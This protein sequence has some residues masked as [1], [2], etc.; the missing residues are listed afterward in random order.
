[1]SVFINKSAL[2][3]CKLLSSKLIFDLLKVNSPDTGKLLLGMNC[4][5]GVLVLL[6]LLTRPL[7][8]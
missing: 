4:S 1:M 8:Y 3:V 7:N 6:T 5:L 2:L